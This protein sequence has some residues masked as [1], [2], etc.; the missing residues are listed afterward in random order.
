MIA[1]VLWVQMVVSGSAKGIVIKTADSTYFGKVSTHIKTK[2]PETAF[3]KGI[4]NVSRLLIRFML[5]LIPLGIYNKCM[6]A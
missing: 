2:K 5:V 1:S 6:E 4:K 3:Q